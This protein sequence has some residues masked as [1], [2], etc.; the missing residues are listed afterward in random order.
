MRFPVSIFASLLLVVAAFPIARAADAPA[1]V[2]TSDW[3]GY[4]KL[5]FAVAG[6][7][8]LLVKPKTTAPGN[9]W[10]WR[11]EFFGH[12]PQGDIALLGL[13][14]HVAYIKVSDMYGAPP[15]IDLM[16]Q[17][18]EYLVKTYG[19]NP[20]AVLEGFSRGGLYA[21]NFAATHPD[22]TAALYLDAPVLDIRSWPGGKGAGK[23]DA[24]CWQQALDLYGLTEETVK[25]F[26]GNPLDRL[27]PIA[28]AKIPI[29][30]ICGDADKVVPYN[31]NAGILEERY[32]K[33]GGN[34]SVILKPGGDHH[35]H[36]LK[37]PQPIVDFL[38]KYAY[39]K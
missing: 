3:N 28:A 10:I 36:S 34:V 11:T 25:D 7:P 12:E 17:F 21:V 16:S 13:G 23:G 1:A 33:M 32:K 38:V 2:K 30:A 22:N 35:P 8:A 39:P 31:E 29:L 4:E 5:D 24:R 15:A 26:K 19:L 9:P 27:E 14:W 20:R 18:H 6:C 37:D